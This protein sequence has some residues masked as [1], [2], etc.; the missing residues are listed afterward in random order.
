QGAPASRTTL[1]CVP[2]PL[3]GRGKRL[4]FCF[5]RLGTTGVLSTNCSDAYTATA[6]STPI[7]GARPVEGA[8]LECFVPH[9]ADVAGFMQVTITAVGPDNKGLADPI[10]HYVAT[11]GA[12]IHEI[13]MYDRDNEHLFAMM[14]RI[15][16]P[17]ADEPVPVL[18]ERL[19]EIGRLKGLTI[20]TWSRDEHQRSPRIAL[21]TTYRPE[22]AL[23]IL[24]DI[25]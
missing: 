17:E 25:R 8:I 2:K 14:L 12:N 3:R 9:L 6:G 20:R 4:V 21:C 18:R 13:Q 11:A 1:G 10:V 16:W 7:D 24:R 22:P 15:E 19:N 5:V 23:A